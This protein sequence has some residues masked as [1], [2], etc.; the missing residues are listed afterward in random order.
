MSQPTSPR[1]PQLHARWLDGF[2][3]EKESNEAV[4]SWM[5]D[6]EAIIRGW[7]E[8]SGCITIQPISLCSLDPYSRWALPANGLFIGVCEGL[9]LS[10]E[11]PG[12]LGF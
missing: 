1:A 7:G 9:A 4:L 10:L 12:W 6:L 8:R 2:S 11:F 5:G 3:S